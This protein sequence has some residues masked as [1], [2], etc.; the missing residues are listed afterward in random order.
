MTKKI[1][2]HAREKAGK[3][4]R[5]GGK[6]GKDEQ[7]RPRLPLLSGGKDPTLAERFEEELH[8]RRSD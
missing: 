7:P 2:E 5:G 8:G 4:G 3:S 1:G 6:T